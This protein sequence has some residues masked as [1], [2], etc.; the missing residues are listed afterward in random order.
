MNF[1]MNKDNVHK[2]EDDLDKIKLTNIEWI[3]GITEYNFVIGGK[4]MM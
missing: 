3:N 4:N 2:S 1:I